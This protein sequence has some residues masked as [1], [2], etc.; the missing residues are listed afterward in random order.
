MDPWTALAL[1][2]QEQQRQ[3]DCI[4][5]QRTSS[6][7]LLMPILKTG[8]MFKPSETLFWCSSPCSCIID[9]IP[10]NRSWF[11]EQSNSGSISLNLSGFYFR[12]CLLACRLTKYRVLSDDPFRGIRPML[13]LQGLQPLILFFEDINFTAWSQH[14]KNLPQSQPSSLW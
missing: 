4:T 2:I 3:K 9:N 14:L 5:P 8:F 12:A 6:Q 11:C 1:T 10:P 7:I 13:Q